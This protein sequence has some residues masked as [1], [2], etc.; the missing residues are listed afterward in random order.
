MALNWCQDINFEFR[1]RHFTTIGLGNYPENMLACWKLICL[2]GRPSPTAD[3]V[4]SSNICHRYM[5][6]SLPSA[7]TIEKLAPA[8]GLHS[9]RVGTFNVGGLKAGKP[10]SRQGLTPRLHKRSGQDIEIHE[11]PVEETLF[12][13]S[14]QC[15]VIQSPA[16]CCQVYS[17][18]PSLPKLR[19]PVINKPSL[20]KHKYSS[21]D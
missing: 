18:I 11:A 20:S 8:L 4:S 12:G 21:E 16:S 7:L 19:K 10:R 1:R 14:P 17:K 2:N 6:E 9:G 15:N 13:W 5:N 3:H